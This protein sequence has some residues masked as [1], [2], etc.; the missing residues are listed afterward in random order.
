MTNAEPP[1]TILSYATPASPPTRQSPYAVASLVVS[2][3]SIS[4]FVLGLGFFDVP[5]PFDAYKHHRIGTVAA[6][7][8]LILSVA[9][10]GQPNR[11]RTLAHAA[12]TLAAMT[13]LAY[14]LLVPL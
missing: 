12:I 5:L 13:V 8:A 14:V 9:A 10:Y 4:W 11:K 3:L 7:L 2:V 1:K 6:V